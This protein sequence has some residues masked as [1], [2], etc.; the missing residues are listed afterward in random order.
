MADGNVVFPSLGQLIPG[1]LD[2]FPSE[3]KLWPPLFYQRRG[4]KWGISCG[5]TI[6]AGG[7]AGHLSGCQAIA[8]SITW[9]FLFVCFIPLSLLKNII[10]FLFQLLFVIWTHRFLLIWTSSPSHQGCGDE[11]SEWAAAWYLLCLW[12]NHNRTTNNSPLCCQ[13]RYTWATSTLAAWFTFWILF[14]SSGYWV[15]PQQWWVLNHFYEDQL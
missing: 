7:Q 6:T 10:M 1:V 4:E 11:S 9:I 14:C 13:P 12:L 8:L 5:I 2:T 3:S 15:N